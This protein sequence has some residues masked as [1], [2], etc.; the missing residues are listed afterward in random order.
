MY[1][2]CIQILELLQSFSNLCNDN[3]GTAQGYHC[4]LIV[5]V[6]VW[7]DRSLEETTG[8]GRWMYK[9]QDQPLT[10][11]NRN[12]TYIL[13]IVIFI[14]NYKS[15]IIIRVDPGHFETDIALQHGIQYFFVYLGFSSH[16]RIFHLYGMVTLLRVANYLDIEMITL[17]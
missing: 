13:K 9:Y 4:P 15:S 10:I 3:L 6:S 12:W 14:K 2:V 7:D 8:H 11:R 5:P 17:V 16:A 1:I